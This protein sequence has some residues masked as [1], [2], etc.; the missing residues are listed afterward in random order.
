MY[1]QK[2]STPYR[3]KYIDVYKHTFAYLFHGKK[4]LY[5]LSTSGT[6]GAKITLT[7]VTVSH[8]SPNCCFFPA[9]LI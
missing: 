7:S 2:C 5:Y 9:P 8:E 3:Y 6:V 1:I 4:N